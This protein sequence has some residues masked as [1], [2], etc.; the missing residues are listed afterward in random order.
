MAERFSILQAGRVNIRTCN[1]QEIGRLGESI[2]QTFLEENDCRI[3]ARNWRAGRWG[4]VDL[5]ARDGLATTFVE[6]KTRTSRY[7]NAE[8]AVTETKL[9]HMQ[10]V[11]LEWMVEHGWAGPIRFDIIGVYLRPER[12]PLVRWLQDVAG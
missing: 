9:G 5:V 4:E 8:E 12:E 3:L 1:R 6:V 10:R 11:A 7:A 2:A